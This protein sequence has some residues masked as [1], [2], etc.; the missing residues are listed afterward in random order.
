MPEAKTK[1]NSSGILTPSDAAISRLL[2]PARIIMPMRVLWIT[3]YSRAGDDQANSG[4]E[5]TVDRIGKRF[6]E[7]DRKIEQRRHRHAVDFIAEKNAAQFFEDQDQAEGEQHLIEMIALVKPAEN[8][9]LQQ[10]TDAEGDH[11][12]KWNA[13]ATDCRS[14]WRASRRDKRRPCKNCHGRD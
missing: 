14:A 6:G 13:P 11:D 5:Q 1:A 2:L 8:R 3:K 12:R 10:E 4:D 7:R 9:R